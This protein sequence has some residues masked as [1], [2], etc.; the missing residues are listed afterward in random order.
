MKDEKKNW[1]QQWGK[2]DANF[3]AI[4]HGSTNMKQAVSSCFSFIPSIFMKNKTVKR[5]K[6]RRPCS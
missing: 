4:F 3:G 6:R 2:I 1:F 5:R